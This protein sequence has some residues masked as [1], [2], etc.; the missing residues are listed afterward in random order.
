MCRVSLAKLAAVSDILVVAASLTQ[1]TENI[2]NAEFLG[3]MKS[4]AFL[5]NISRGGLVDQDALVTALNTGTIKGITYSSFT[6]FRPYLQE[7]DWMSVLQSLCPPA[8]PC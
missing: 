4:T 3:N 8:A 1:E 7:Q 2:V 6:S 5:I